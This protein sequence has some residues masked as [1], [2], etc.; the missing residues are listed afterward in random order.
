MVFSDAAAPSAFCLRAS[1]SCASSA[2]TRVRD[3]ER[4]ETVASS[5]STARSLASFKAA[6]CCSVA[7]LPSSSFCNSSLSRR[8]VSRSLCSC[9][10]LF[11]C[12]ASTSLSLLSIVAICSSIFCSVVDARVSKTEIWSSNFCSRC[13]A[14][15]V[16]VTNLA[17]AASSSALASSA[18]MRAVEAFMS[19]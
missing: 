7:A 16:C 3:C 12:V 19:A 1:S 14:C 18:T 11:L 8:C 5:C 17:R 6:D 9:T 15:A 13:C 4:A 2:S 10:V